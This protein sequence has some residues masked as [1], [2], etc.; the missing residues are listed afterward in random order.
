MDVTVPSTS[1][2]SPLAKLRVLDASRGGG[3]AACARILAQLG[4]EVARV[5]ASA[6]PALRRSEV[7]TDRA[8]SPFDLL[9]IDL[10]PWEA[11]AQGLDPAMLVH[12]G[13][14]VQLGASKSSIG[15]QHEDGYTQVPL[16][17]L[18]ERD[19]VVAVL[20]FERN[21]RLTSAELYYPPRVD[22]RGQVES[23]G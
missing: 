19:L 20:V 2:G 14:V 15:L 17:S 1:I 3:A 23:L 16:A 6:T 4:A 10:Q 18:W 11:L 5:E 12:P 21:R 13:R 8:T 22:E 9:I 7:G